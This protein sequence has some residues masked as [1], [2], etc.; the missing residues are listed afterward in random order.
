MASLKTVQARYTATFVGFMALVIVLTVYGIGQFVSPRLTAND[1][2]MLT[3]KA[4]D[5]SNE[6]KTEL[7]RVQAQARVITELVPQLSSD[8]I[9]RL[10]PFMV[11]QYGEAKVFGGGIWPLPNV[12]TPGRAKH[13]TFYHRDASGK[14]IVNTHWNS[15]ESL[16]YFEQGW[17]KGGLNSPAGQCAWAPAYQ[18]AASPEPRTNCAMAITK[19]GQP[20]G[21][22]T[23]DVTLGF[24]NKL[25]EAKEQEVHGRIMIIE[26]DG[27]ILSN[28]PGSSDKIVLRN[29]SEL[30]AQSPF[31]NGVKSALAVKGTGT[32]RLTYQNSDGE[33]STLFLMP[34][35]GTPWLLAV[36]QNTDLLKSQSEAVLK[37]LAWLQIPMVLVLLVLMIVALRTLMNRLGV[38]KTNIDTLSAG[39]ADLTR[40][41]AVKG[42][43]EVDQV[44]ES[45]NNFI[46]YLQRMMLDVSSSTREIASG[47]E[48]LR[49]QAGA[50]NAI[51]IRHANETD[52]AVTAITEMSSTADEV[53]RSAAQTASFTQS[54]NENAQVSKTVVADASDSVNALIGEVD[55]ATSK[56]QSMEQDAKRI[57][58]VLAVIGEIA[59]Q[60]NLLAL[61][62]AI[63]A[64]RAGEQGRGFA[65]VADEVRALAAR[66]QASTSEIN[67]MLGSLQQGV[68]AAVAAME[69][70]RQSCQTTAGKTTA[71]TS[72]L[73]DMTRSVLQIN[74][75]S[76]QIATAAEEQ[77]AVSEEISRN[78]IA[79]RHIV[80]ELVEGGSSNE[81]STAA[82]SESNTRL[83]ALVRRFKVS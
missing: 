25:V 29:V 32:S 22:S 54:A 60:T 39:D 51:L 46:A 61:N 70:T 81:R 4:A 76:T 53:A 2:N 26:A 65:V 6:I 75:L 41:I 59:G 9:D 47:I 8:D 74:D 21:V 58:A 7:A 12:R 15:P 55:S 49:S 44:G 5:I 16:N 67:E 42:H 20:W 17:H 40:R 10:L 64:A 62:A 68:S 52:Q 83:I 78:I 56:V 45:V 72:G 13:S 71:V 37:T 28:V 38:L 19:D 79:V 24:F 66:T 50:T 30:A 23:I 31:I 3:A 77:S 82:L 27:K 18:D 63:E 11:N 33:E 35:A 43:D 80:E 34:V 57:N 36:S 14:L 48:Q 1:E 69:K 73:D